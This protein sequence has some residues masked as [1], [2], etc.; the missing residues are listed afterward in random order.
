MPDGGAAELVA[1]LARAVRAH[2]V[3]VALR[4]EVACAEAVAAVGAAR[5]QDL[6]W[7]GRATL[8]HRPED[9]AAY[10]AAFTAVLEERVTW[11]APSVPVPTEVLV[12]GEG[13]SDGEG[14]GDDDDRVLR[15]S[16]VEQLRQVDLATCTVDERVQLHRAISALR[17]DVATRRS[18]RR[19][20][21][22]R[23]DELDLRRT[24]HAALATGGEPLRL[25]QRA[26]SDRPRRLVLLLDVSG[27][28]EPYARA[29]V[30][31]AHA[32]V[33]S[34]GAG[35]VEAFTLGT[36][37]TRITR[38]LTTRDPDEALAR[39]AGDV[40][41]WSGGTRLGDALGQFVDR[42]GARGMAR[43]AVVVVLSDGWDRGDPALVAEAMARLHRLAHHVVWVNPLRAV[44]G[45]EPLAQGM[46]AAL[47][48]VDTFV[49]G[50]SLAD[51]EG[52]AHLLATLSDVPPSRSVA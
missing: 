34:R 22:R 6:Y 16:A 19:R 25:H 40:A 39:T 7:A 21:A 3:P 35:R 29:L 37:L 15:H 13:G 5:R 31:F 17:V 44:P 12:E 50:A 4:S 18:R 30:R 47:P 27:S 46:A 49:P 26:P 45:Y 36:R 23:G 1:A 51:L 28:M 43:G 14:V 24:V 52:L 42:W 8:I 10:D 38:A 41:D 2:G 20:P 32:A 9:A 11:S 33:T 48:H